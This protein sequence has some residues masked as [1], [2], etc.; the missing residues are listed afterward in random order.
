MR[1]RAFIAIALVAVS[2]LLLPLAVAGGIMFGIIPGNSVSCTVVAEN[3]S[4][5]YIEMDCE[6]RASLAAKA[7]PFED[8]RQGDQYDCLRY[9]YWVTRP[10]SDTELTGGCRKAPR[11][12]QPSE[13]N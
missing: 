13:R 7:G 6:G 1:Q 3:H 9:W 12:E 11:A 2:V 10:L 5:Q 8:A 4:T